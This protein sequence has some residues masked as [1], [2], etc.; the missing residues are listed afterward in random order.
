[1]LLT[2]SFI[3][4]YAVLFQQKED[5]TNALKSETQRVNKVRENIQ[6]KLRAVED[7]KVDV[8]QQKETLKGQ[9]IGL[10]RGELALEIY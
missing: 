9:I 3:A 7:Q 6:R 5:E 8:E 10:E 1:M 2:S 4:V